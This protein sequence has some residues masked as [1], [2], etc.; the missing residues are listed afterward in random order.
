MNARSLNPVFANRPTTIFAV[1]S[2]LARQHGAVNL[3]Q[4]F[5]DEDGPPEL[6]EA[7]IRALKTGPNQYAPVQGVPELRR[8]LALSNKR[9]YG[10][11]IDWESETLVTAGF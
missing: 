5:P 11:D 1:M 10:L 2:A 6:I 4:G 8:A 7:A 9:F 3:G